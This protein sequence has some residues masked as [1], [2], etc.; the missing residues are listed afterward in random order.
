MTRHF[1][2]R[3][4]IEEHGCWL[5]TGPVSTNGYGQ[6]NN[7]GRPTTPHRAVWVA[8]HGD[9]GPHLFV[10]H[11][12]DNRMCV[13]PSH[14]SLGTPADNTADCVRKRRHAYGERNGHHKLTRAQATQI[15][16]LRWQG[17]TFVEI[18]RMFGVAKA[19]PQDICAG[20]SW[21]SPPP[22]WLEHA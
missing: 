6:V 4:A 11:T 22:M 8:L 5:W 16:A 14:L 18:A 9:P 13:R 21:N 10:M 17:H 20:R 7:L 2:E 19:T 12:C 3:V 15:L 1:W